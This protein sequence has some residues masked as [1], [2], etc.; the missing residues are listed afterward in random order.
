MEKLTKE[1]ETKRDK[2][3]AN[4]I[5]NG[6]SSKES[7]DRIMSDPVMR[8]AINALFAMNKGE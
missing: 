2:F 6:K 1:Q 5:K 8:K 3:L 7:I 4:Q